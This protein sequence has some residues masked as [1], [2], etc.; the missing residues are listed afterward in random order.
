MC[1]ALQQWQLAVGATLLA[2]LVL[3]GLKAS[4]AQIEAKAEP[5]GN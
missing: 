5:N 3:R 1:A 2:F 4:E